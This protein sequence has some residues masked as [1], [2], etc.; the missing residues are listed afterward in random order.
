[1]VLEYSFDEPKIIQKVKW[2][3]KKFLVEIRTFAEIEVQFN[4]NQPSKS[5]SFEIN[6]ENKFVTIVIP[7]RIVW[8]PYTV[9]LNDEKILNFSRFQIMEPMFGN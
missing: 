9:L 5:L 6:G 4:F 2:E 7:I 8:E 1:M 3:D